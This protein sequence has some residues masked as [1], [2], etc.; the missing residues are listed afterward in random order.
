EFFARDLSKTVV[1]HYR[2]PQV[3]CVIGAVCSAFAIATE[4]SDNTFSAAA[5][6]TGAA[7][8]ALISDM[9]ARSGRGSPARASSSSRVSFL[10]SPLSATSHL[11]H[12]RTRGQSVGSRC[13]VRS[14]AGPRTLC[15]FKVAHRVPRERTEGGADGSIHAPLAAAVGR[16]RGAHRRVRGVGIQGATVAG[17]AGRWAGDPA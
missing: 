13:A 5:R 15:R 14:H 3:D 8:F 7:T 1:R 11:L 16:R 9:A 2:L 12:R 10:N 4:L 6:F 17:T